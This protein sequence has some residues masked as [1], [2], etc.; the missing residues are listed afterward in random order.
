[1][2]RSR[3]PGSG[4]GR[5]RSRTVRGSKANAVDSPRVRSADRRALPTYARVSPGYPTT[6]DDRGASS[7][8][9]H[10]VP[11]PRYTIHRHII[12]SCMTATRYSGEDEASLS[13]PPP[14]GVGRSIGRSVQSRD[15]GPDAD[16]RSPL[17]VGSEDRASRTRS[18]THSTEPPRSRACES[19]PPTGLSLSP[20]RAVESD[21][22]PRYARTEPTSAGRSGPV[23][24][25][26]GLDGGCR[27]TDRFCT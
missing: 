22:E 9:F 12:I 17:A 15:T 25:R 3:V 4:F 8:G 14:V 10:H 26:A 18:V 19:A 2:A 7:V 21:V 24:G 11:P 16:A 13:A 23:V 5:R 27:H 6:G 1:M 20:Y